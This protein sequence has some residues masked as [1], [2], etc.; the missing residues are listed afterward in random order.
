[1]FFFSIL[2][3]LSVFGTITTTTTTT[4]YYN[5]IFII[6]ILLSFSNVSFINDCVEE[7]I[8]NCDFDSRVTT[9]F[10]PSG[11]ALQAAYNSLCAHTYK[12][13]VICKLFIVVFLLNINLHAAYS[14]L[15]FV[16]FFCFLF[17][18]H[19]NRNLQVA[20]NSLCAL[21]Y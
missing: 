17:F 9:F 15:L 8:K 19:R 4:Y 16:V 13:T 21:I 11:Q 2:L 20:H 3:L 7:S 1:M 5:Y 18:F 6:I 10:G 12:G 14:S